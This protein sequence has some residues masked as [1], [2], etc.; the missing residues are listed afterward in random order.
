[1]A[2]NI[3]LEFTIAGVGFAAVGELDGD[4]AFAF[5]CNVQIPTRSHHFAFGQVDA[6]PFGHGIHSGG[7]S[8]VI[9]ESLHAACV[10]HVLAEADGVDVRQVVGDQSLPTQG[11]LGSGHRNIEHTVH[12]LV[13]LILADHV[14]SGLGKGLIGSNNF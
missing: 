11:L 3:E 14:G 9:A 2:V 12:G 1:M 8:E 10:G 4:P 13:A 5:D 7:Q 6:G